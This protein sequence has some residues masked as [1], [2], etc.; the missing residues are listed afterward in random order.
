MPGP[1][2]AEA[3]KA[4]L[5]GKSEVACL[6][7]REHGQYGEGHPFLA[8]PCP[9]SRLEI[10]APAL[11]PRAGVPIILVDDGDGV[12]ERAAPVLA[13]LGYRDLSW[14]AGGAT[15][16]AAAGFTLFKGVNLPSKTL[17]ELLETEWHVPRIDV[18]TLAA[19]QAEG[20]SIQL[21]DGRPG[22]EYRKMT[23][24]GAASMP[25]GELA[26]R[27]ADSVPDPALPVVI[28][29][30]G[31]TRSIV[32]AASLSLAGVPNP[33]FAL[34]N[35]TQGWALSGRALRH[36]ADPG[37]MPALSQSARRESRARA[38]A[39]IEQHRL[40]VIAPD[41]LESLS[42]DPSRTLYLF[43]VRSDA[44]FAEG[45]LRGAVHAPAVQLVQASDAWIGVRRARVV[46]GCDTGLRA[47]TTAIFLAA[48]NYDVFVLPRIG[49]HPAHPGLRQ[50][51]PPVSGE[52]PSL[53]QI[54]AEAALALKE[55]GGALLDLRGSLA[56]RAGHLAGARWA[57]RPRLARTDPARPVALIGSADVV[58][59]AA[60]DLRA[61]GYGDIRHVAGD[62]ASWQA[63]GLPVEATPDVPSDA[64]AIDHL[65][66]V[67][68][69][70]D[71][72]L[73]A[74][75]RYLAWEMGLIGQL[76]AAERAE[77]RIGPGPFAGT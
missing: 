64:A 19:W 63:R 13:R 2:P 74:A 26:H 54:T 72:N 69:R 73:D 32:G 7:V 61:E 55:A 67:H 76:D 23:L 37:P 29:C 10:L 66:F 47:A 38:D 58:G 9:Y 44:E 20:R 24:P 52:L 30:A 15:A 56:F 51:D 18:E 5:H 71:G 45:T 1:I 53:L 75:R 22:S 46:L 70:H 60:A 59:L 43:D 27:M 25:N 40:N 21:F 11:V 16:W 14:I 49:D 8:V 36:G 4:V 12:A 34:E 33:V 3:A 57:V 28:H 31:R 42:A 35:G 68:D 6:D 48:L 41:D 39:V 77:F 65:F 17:G 50:P 62:P